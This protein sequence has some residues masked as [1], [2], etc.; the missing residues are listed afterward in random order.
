[1]KNGVHPILYIL[2]FPF[3]PHSEGEIT[4]EFAEVL[5]LQPFYSNSIWI[6][7]TVSLIFFAASSLLS[8]V[9]GFPEEEMSRF[10]CAIGL[11][12]CKPDS[13]KLLSS[14]IKIERA[15]VTVF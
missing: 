9:E 3:C 12:R 10:N 11:L 4:R 14:E 6:G 7:V 2:Y 5:L 8:V 13:S 15:M 1:M